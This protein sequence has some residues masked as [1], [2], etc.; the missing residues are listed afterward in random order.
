M[1]ANGNTNENGKPSR[2]QSYP[3][4]QV[5]A[6]DFIRTTSPVYLRERGGGA[7]GW[8]AQPGTGTTSSRCVSGFGHALA[9][10]PSVDTVLDEARQ[11][12][13]S[14]DGIVH[15]AAPPRRKPLPQQ[16]RHSVMLPGVPELASKATEQQPKPQTA[17]EIRQQ[18]RR[19]MGDMS[20]STTQQHSAPNWS[21]D[22]DTMMVPPAV[23]TEAAAVNARDGSN[24][25]AS[26][27]Q[28]RLRG[29][30]AR[31]HDRHDWA[32]REIQQNGTLGGGRDGA[33]AKSSSLRAALKAQVTTLLSRLR[34]R[35]LAKRKPAKRPT[36]IIPMEARGGEEQRAMPS[37]FHL[38]MPDESQPGK[39]KCSSCHGPECPWWHPPAQEREEQE[40]QQ[41]L[42]AH[43]GEEQ[44]YEV[45]Q[46]QQQ[47]QQ[48]TYQQDGKE[49]DER[50]TKSISHNAT[51]SA[52][53]AAAGLMHPELSFSSPPSLTTAATVTTVAT[54]TRTAP[55]IATS[56]TSAAA[57][58]VTINTSAADDTN[59]TTATTTTTT[60][61]PSGSGAT[62]S[63]KR[64]SIS[65]RR[66][67]SNIFHSS[68]SAQNDN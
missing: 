45:E 32:Q 57:T 53:A 66:R 49:E 42:H 56:H 23:T 25:A 7:S 33:A 21:L 35:K 29:D 63:A 50:Q 61:Q 52:A 46:Q 11:Y 64:F 24:V 40:Q 28:A 13:G 36:S 54:T 62:K 55:T 67:W 10:A 60:T 9:A 14:H 12:G 8:T 5:A 34:G 30:R 19:T 6:R 15:Q 31:W 39:T 58:N 3:T 1:S 48:E 26:P 44:D 59:A 47:Q 68:S 22:I 4:P 16:Q 37:V 43:E 20:T 18:R 65:G 51:V 38:R 17:R 41:M 2:R 27:A